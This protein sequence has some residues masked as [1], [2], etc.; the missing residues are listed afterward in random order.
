MALASEKQLEHLGETQGCAN[1]DHDLV[2]ELSR[3]LDNLW[4]YDQYIENADWRESLG[5]FWRQQKEQELE[6]VRQ[7]KQL[8]AEEIRNGCF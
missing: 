3:R 5:N 1:H 6:N 7:L 8:L 4:R 2:H